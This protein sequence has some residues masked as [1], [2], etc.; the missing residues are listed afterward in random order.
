MLFNPDVAQVS[1]LNSF[2]LPRPSCAALTGVEHERDWCTAPVAP[3]MDP[4]LLL[5][6]D[7]F[8]GAYAPM[9]A[10]LHQMH[11]GAEYAF[12]QFARGACPSL[13][14][15]GAPYCR[16]ISSK[17]AAYVER[18]PSIKTVVLAAN[19][20]GYYVADGV[21]MEQALVR[22]VAFY[23]KLGKRVVVLLSP[24]N[25]ANP[26]ACI[27]RAIRFQMPIF[28]IFHWSVPTSLMTTTA[29]ICCRNCSASGFLHS[30]RFPTCAAKAVAR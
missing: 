10:R 23:R 5:I 15:Y 18:T 27:M 25:G 19:W 26:K 21:A 30:I 22:T 29:I 13:L 12:R 20:P 2:E 24:P 7:S 16:E 3:V 4:A 8:S 28:A 1:V 11:P 17:I 9:F 14:E 6:G